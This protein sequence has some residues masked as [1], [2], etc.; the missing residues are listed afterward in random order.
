MV[1]EDIVEEIEPR[2]SLTEF[3]SSPYLDTIAETIEREYYCRQVSRFHYPVSLMIKLLVIKC[4]RKQSYLRA[5][6][7][8]TEEDCFNL[9]AEKTEAGYLLPDPATPIIL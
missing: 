1:K 6:S 8:P 4:F 3:L 9:G 7:L 5:I 2:S